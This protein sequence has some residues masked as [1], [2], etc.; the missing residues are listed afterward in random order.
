MR[1]ITQNARPI[2]A[3]LLAGAA[4]L[5]AITVFRGCNQ[6]RPPGLDAVFGSHIPAPIGPIGTTP[7]PDT[8]FVEIFRDD[9]S[10]THARTENKPVQ[11]T[12]SLTQ[13]AIDTLA[14]ALKIAT[15]Q[16][17]ELT[18]VKAVL[19]GELKA[20]YATID[21]QNGSIRTYYP[22]RFM[23]AYTNTID[24]TMNYIYN[25]EL[26]F[27]DVLDKKKLFAGKRKSYLD[28][29]SPDSNFR[30]NSVQRYRRQM[31]V[32]KDKIWIS[33]VAESGWGLDPIVL[34]SL[35]GGLELRVN[36]EGV[37]SGYFGAGYGALVNQSLPAGDKLF[38]PY[39]RAGIAI[40]PVKF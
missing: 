6:A 23:N 16:I 8:A 2:A 20:A 33:A 21:K 31:P 25:A 30:I 1:T 18:R 24:S 26:L 36:P 28:I 34:R 10:M 37:L 13:Y 17:A 7:K 11:A 9:A 15:E 3:L 38:T 40:T 22:G 12:E 19:S 5:I 32:R 29:F 39:G 4:L 14:P 35:S 27:V